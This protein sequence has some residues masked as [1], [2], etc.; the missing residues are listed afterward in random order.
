MVETITRHPIPTD[1]WVKATW[2]EFV[3]TAYSTP[4]QNGR[5]Y[6]DHDYMRIEMSPLGSGL[7]HCDEIKIILSGIFYL[8]YY[9]DP[10]RSFTD[11][12]GLSQGTWETASVM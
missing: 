5:A 4:Y 8:R 7:I 9:H 1:T 2:D 12:A 11:C 3:A 10:H 6:Y